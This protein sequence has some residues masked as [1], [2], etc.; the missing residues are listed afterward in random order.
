MVH[1]WFA[2]SD[3]WDS[4][5]EQ[6]EQG[7]VSF[8][9]ILRIYLTHYRGE[10]SATFQVMAMTAEPVSRT[11]S[12][13]T[14]ELGISAASQ[15][16]QTQYVKSSAAAPAL[17]GRV[18]HAGRPGDPEELLLKLDEPAAGAAHMFAM[19]L[20]PQTCLSIRLYLYGHGAA[21]IAA[22][23]EPRWQAWLT[24]GSH[25]LAMRTSWPRRRHSPPRRSAKPELPTGAELLRL[26]SSPM[27]PMSL[28]AICRLA[29]TSDPILPGSARAGSPALSG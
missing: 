3:D 9:R 11:W 2:D 20:G 13:L 19:A 16:Q 12:S 10:P 8:F 18:E 24:S 15:T 17:A 5:F 14:N 21:A 6:T 29:Y 22:R 4:Q 28:P 1:S 7:W 23:E 27:T 25:R 26:N